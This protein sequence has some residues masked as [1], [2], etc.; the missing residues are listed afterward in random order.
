MLLAL[1]VSCGHEGNGSEPGEFERRAPDIVR[2]MN[3]GNFKEVREALHLRL[4]SNLTEERLAEAW[5]E[6]VDEHGEL[7]G[8][9]ALFQIIE[10]AR[11]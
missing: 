11:S 7:T 10:T 1:A 6:F 2:A 5:G 4:Q 9:P 8:A 3:D